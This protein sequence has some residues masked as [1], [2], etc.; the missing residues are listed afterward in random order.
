MSEHR[1]DTSLRVLHTS[2]YFLLA[3]HR[4]RGAGLLH[5][6]ANPYPSLDV[7]VAECGEVVAA[8]PRCRTSG[9]VLDFRSAPSNNAAEFE[10]AMAELRAAVNKRF[11]RVAL[12]VRTVAGVLQGQRL[13]SVDVGGHIVVPT[14]DEEEAWRIAC[15]NV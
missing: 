4:A 7:V 11:A 14:R 12:L 5:R 13:S 1:S 6:T 9:L 2:P 15:G 8:L 3:I 10:E